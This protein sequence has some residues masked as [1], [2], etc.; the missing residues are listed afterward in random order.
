MAI[1][2]KVGG[3]DRLVVGFFLRTVG[4][5]GGSGGKIGGGNRQLYRAG[6]ENIW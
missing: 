4:F 3:E 5:G 6:N 1:F 2:W